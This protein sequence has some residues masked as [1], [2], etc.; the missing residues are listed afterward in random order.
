MHTLSTLK[1]SAFS[2]IDASMWF[3]NGAA[4][5]MVCKATGTPVCMLLMDKGVPPY[6][7]RKNQAPVSVLQL[8]GQ[9]TG[10][11]AQ[12]WLAVCKNCTEELTTQC[13][14][15][16]TWMTQARALK[17]VS[18]KVNGQ[19]ALG[20]ALIQKVLFHVLSSLAYMKFEVLGTRA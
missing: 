12:A 2:T 18:C 8:G 16:R 5:K 11:A 13:P 9:L 4:C 14:F 6:H 10:R 17:F 3:I 19:T 20:S 7:P 1:T 15:Y